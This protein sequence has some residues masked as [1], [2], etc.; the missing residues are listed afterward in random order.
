MKDSIAFLPDTP[1]NAGKIVSTNIVKMEWNDEDWAWP[2]RV[3]FVRGGTYEY[4]VNG[5]PV[6][7]A[8]GMEWMTYAE[9]NV[10]VAEDVWKLLKAGAR[11][12]RES[13]KTGEYIRGSHGAAF[14]Y[15]I[16]KP[17]AGNKALYRK[18]E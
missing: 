13:A 17:I 8:T 16:K 3:T 7:S 10:D 11:W 14:D 12:S 18:V 6:V 5:I 1:E 15:L 4:D 9:A 2:L